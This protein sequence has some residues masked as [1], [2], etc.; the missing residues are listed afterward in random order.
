MYSIAG[1]V[2]GGGGL[3]MDGAVDPV[4]NGYFMLFA[5]IF[6]YRIF[7]LPFTNSKHS[8]RQS[9]GRTVKCIVTGKL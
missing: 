7:G 2:D 5:Q 9:L 1:G 6:C 8:T 4:Q 3:R